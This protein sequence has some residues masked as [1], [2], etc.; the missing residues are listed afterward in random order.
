MNDKEKSRK[1]K[2]N[3]YVSSELGEAVRRL[4]ALSDRSISNVGMRAIAHY[5]ADHINDGDKP[6]EV[7][8]ERI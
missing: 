2:L 5:V 7:N 4:A 1:V 6:I 8:I 3:I